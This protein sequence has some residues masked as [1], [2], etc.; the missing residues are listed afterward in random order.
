MFLTAYSSH[1]CDL[2]QGWSG[3]VGSQVPWG[4]KAGICLKFVWWNISPKT[5]AKNAAQEGKTSLEFSGEALCVIE[6]GIWWTTGWK[7]MLENCAFSSKTQPARQMEGALSPAKAG[8]HHF[9]CKEA[10]PQAT[11]VSVPVR[12]QNATRNCQQL[13]PKGGLWFIA[14]GVGSRVA[15]SLRTNYQ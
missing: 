7:L 15:A 5:E 10:Y 12:I 14:H 2:W 1:I 8:L 6:G 9:C 4:P 13:G 11:K 3:V